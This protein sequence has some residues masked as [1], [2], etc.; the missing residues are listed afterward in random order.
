[1]RADESGS[2]PAQTLQPLLDVA[3]WGPALSAS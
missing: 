2:A 1:L 3:Q